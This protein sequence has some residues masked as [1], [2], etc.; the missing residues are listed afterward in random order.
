MTFVKEGARRERPR[1]VGFEVLRLA[2]SR[3][4]FSVLLTSIMLLTCVVSC[5]PVKPDQS[6]IE[7][8]SPEPNYTELTN[9][10]SVGTVP[11]D[12]GSP[13]YKPLEVP[14]NDIEP[15]DVEPPETEPN[16]VE[17]PGT[18][19]NIIDPNDT[20]TPRVS[21][22]NKCA[23]ILTKFVNKQG[24]VDYN[25][26]RRKRSDLGNLLLE[27]KK[28]DPNEYKSWPKEDKIAFW[29]NA[30][31]LQ[32]MRI[33]VHNYPIN[34]SRW[35]RIFKWHPSSVRYINK[36]VGGIKKQK[37][38]ITREEFTL[39]SIEQRFF[40]E[41]F[42]EPRIFFALFHATLSGP[43]LRNEPYYG[44]KL[45]KQL[46]DQ[47]RK[48]LSST[49]AFKIDERK[50]RVY[51]PLILK[52]TWYGPEF[53]DKYGTDKI[54]KEQSPATRAVLNCIRKYISRKDRNFLERQNYSVKYMPYDWT[55]NDGP[56]KK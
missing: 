42:D 3:F 50:R 14:P 29:I 33:I 38:I 52:S 36:N 49:K 43:P 45:N 2:T 21:F 30:Y 17:T 4:A 40:R 32:L 25:A 18:E 44:H 37:F 31:N 24:M 6:N 13:V 22:H 26:L 48:F 15:N 12:I 19:P 34:S 8:T 9:T 46:D 41:E 20:N 47:A 53:I 5:T 1:I 56:V 16:V 28:L 39:K 55:I 23:P 10:E 54:F 27:F 7:I 11:N 35:E 51:L